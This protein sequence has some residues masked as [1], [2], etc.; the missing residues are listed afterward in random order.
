MSEGIKRAVFRWIHIGNFRFIL[1]S[2]KVLSY[3]LIE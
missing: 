2:A 3:I 1:G